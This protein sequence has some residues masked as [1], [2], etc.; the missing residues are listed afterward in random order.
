MTARPPAPPL[1]VYKT[2]AERDKA[3]DAALADLR[4]I[5]RLHGIALSVAGALIA[6]VGLVTAMAALKGAG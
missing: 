3:M 2:K 6:M 4:F 1:S 5:N